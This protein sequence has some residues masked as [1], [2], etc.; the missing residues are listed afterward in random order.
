YWAIPGSATAQLPPGPAQ[1]TV[2]VTNATDRYTI[3][4]GAI[5]VADDINNPS[6]VV[7]PNSVLEKELAAADDCLLKLLSQRTQMV[8][9]GGKSYTLWSIKDLWAVRNGIYS[10]V[11]AEREAAAGNMRARVIVPVFVNL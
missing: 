9:F 5:T 3:D 2:Q 7:D 6:L 11:I 8:S 4:T 10:R 1:Y